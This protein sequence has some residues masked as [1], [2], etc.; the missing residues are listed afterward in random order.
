[1][2]RFAPEN[3]AQ[4]QEAVAWAVAETTPLAV[5]GSGS[6]AALGRETAMAHAVDVG[7]LSGI[8]LYEPEELILQA[9]AGTTMAEIG[10]ALSANNQELAFEP[11][12]Y[13]P[14]LGREAGE[15]TLGGLIAT[16]LSRP[17]PDQ[18]GRGPRPF[19]GVRGGVRSGRGF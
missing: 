14:L 1:M 3:L 19:F 6:K 7:K 11:P 5:A 9:G 8:A 16:N 13:G 18:V 12:D 2:T 10:E 17:T 4:L 15:G